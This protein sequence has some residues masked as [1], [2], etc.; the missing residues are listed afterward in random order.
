MKTEYRLATIEDIPE[1]LALHQK[2]HISTISEEDKEGGFI[3]AT[4]S[5]DDLVHLIED[6][7]CISL[8]IIENKVVGFVFAA[9]WEYWKKLPIFAYMTEHLSEN[10][11]NDIVITAENSYHHGPVCLDKEHRGQGHLS[12][13]FEISKAEMARKYDIL[14]TF[15]NVLNKPSYVAHKNKLGFDVSKIFKFG[16]QDYYE[17]VK[18]IGL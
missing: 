4:F 14:V 1:I 9:D 8:T 11:I 6:F 2:F 13:M 5:S 18:Y 7:G 10:S 16:D 15:V 3:T 17:I 12:K